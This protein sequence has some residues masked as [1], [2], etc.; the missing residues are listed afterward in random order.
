MATWEIPFPAWSSSI[1]LDFQED[2]VLSGKIA[3]GQPSAVPFSKD[4]CFFEPME[5]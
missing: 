1:R 2:G 5:A 3:D 4:F